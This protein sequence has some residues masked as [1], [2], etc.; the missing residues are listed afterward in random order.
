M[1]V[2]KS[3]ERKM[4]LPTGKW[5]NFWTNKA[6]DGRQMITVKSALDKSPIFVRSGAVIPLYPI[7]QYVG[8]KEINEITLQAYYKAGSETSYLFEDERDGFSYEDGNY[9]FST[10][11]VSGSENE[12]MITQNVEGQYK[13]KHATFKLQIIGLPFEIKEII[14]DGKPSENNNLVIPSNFTEIKI[15]GK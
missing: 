14:V 3:T 4:Y 6:I 10:F 2:E 15:I 5:F 12:L 11:A 13:P 7:Q 1:I 9:A 8:E